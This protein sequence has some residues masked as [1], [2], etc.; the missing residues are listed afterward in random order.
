[1]AK[2]YQAIETKIHWITWTAM[3]SIFVLLVTL[4]VVLQPSRETVF[5]D[6]YLATTTETNFEKKLP[7]D[8]KFQFVDS[9]ED[10]FLGFSKGLYTIGKNDSNLT[11]VFFGE[12]SNAQSAN[13]IANVYARLYGSSLVDPTIAASD[14]YTELEDQVTLYYFEQKAAQFEGTVKSLNEY[15]EAEI[16]ATALPLVLVLLNNE[17]LT[18]AVLSDANIPLQ[19]VNFYDSVLALEEVQALLN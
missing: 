8:N 9:L 15:Y 18:Y 1:M 3:A 13:H 14:L 6:S 11:I 2:K 17:V 5:Y 10:G 19:L 7:R 16:N 12:P 4:I